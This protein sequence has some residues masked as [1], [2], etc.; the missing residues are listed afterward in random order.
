MSANIEAVNNGGYFNQGP[1]TTNFTGLG[2]VAYGDLLICWIIDM[3]FFTPASITGFTKLGADTVAASQQHS[4]WWKVAGASE[5][6]PTITY[7]GGT[8]TGDWYL[9]RISGGARPTAI[10]THAYFNDS[11][12][13]VPTWPLISPS[14]D[15]CLIVAAITHRGTGDNGFVADTSPVATAKANISPGAQGSFFWVQQYLQTTQA[16]IA[17][18][19]TATA[20]DNSVL[21]Q[22]AVAPFVTTFYEKAGMG[23]IG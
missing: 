2:T 8:S 10:N 23:A 9:M 12:P 6:A 13:T 7:S 19:A 21:T 3:L 4:V 14:V 15:E 20:T 5:T 11:T 18:T 16:A 22:L 17:L 1:I